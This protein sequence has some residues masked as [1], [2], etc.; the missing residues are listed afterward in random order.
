MCP[1]P[2]RLKIILKLFLLPGI[3]LWAGQVR[4]SKAADVHKGKPKGFPALSHVELSVA[5]FVCNECLP[6]RIWYIILAVSKPDS[7]STIRSRLCR[8]AEDHTRQAL[9]HS[10]GQVFRL[11]ATSY[12][13]SCS[14][15]C[16]L[17]LTLEEELRSWVATVVD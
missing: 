14:H 15:E 5:V 6:V 2:K 12:T 3:E 8:S 7:R 1:K 10:K 13:L 11:A 17:L 9:S 16:I 4:L